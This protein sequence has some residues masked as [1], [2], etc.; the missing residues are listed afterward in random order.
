MLSHVVVSVTNFDRALAFYR[1]LMAC[2]GHEA[3]FC[4]PDLPWAG[5]QS[6]G[7]ARPLFVIAHPFNGQPHHTGNKLAV[8]CHTPADPAAPS[9]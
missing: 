3:R 6:A 4:E 5:W 8:A 7:G 2:L 1:A 9:P